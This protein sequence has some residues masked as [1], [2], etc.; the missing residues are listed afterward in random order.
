MIEI[1][2]NPVALNGNLLLNVGPTA[3]GTIDPV[4][5]ERLLTMG[6]WLRVNGEAIYGSRN[7]TTPRESKTRRIW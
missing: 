2:V 3:W 5:E 4:Y 6:A 7:W 1:L